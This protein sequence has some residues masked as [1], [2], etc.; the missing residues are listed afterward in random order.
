MR[1]T[2]TTFE[3][4][5][6]G[7]ARVRAPRDDL[8]LERAE[9]PDRFACETGPFEAYERTVD[10]EDLGDGRHRVTETT[11]WVLGI[12]IWGVLFRPLVSRQIARHEA[13]PAPDPVS[14]GDEPGTEPAALTSPWWSPPARLDLRSSQVLSRLCGLSLLAGYLGTVLTQTITY[15]ADEFGSSK[16][17]Q[18]GA[19]AAVRLGV[20][21]SVAIMAVADRRGRQ[22]LL[23]V[24]AVGGSVAAGLTA[25]APGLVVLGATQTV[26]R[27]FS[28]ALALLISVVA[29]EEMPSGGRA[30]AASVMAMTGA[31]GAG[32][33]VMLLPVADVAEPAWRLLYVVPLLALPLFLKIGRRLPESRRFARSHGRST[34][35]GHRMRLLLLAASSFFA[36]VFFAPNTQFQ[37]DFLRDEHGFTA[38]QI[39]IFTILTNT[40]G[41]IGIVVGGRLADTRGRRLV[42]AVG[43]IGGAVLL[44]LRFLVGG[45][46]LW[47]LS[48]A[49]TIVAAVT[50]PALAVYGPELFPTALRGKANGYISVAGVAGSAVGLV[51]AGRLADRYGELGPGLAMLAVGP[52][53]VAALVMAFYPET[54]HLELEDLNPEDAPS[55]ITPL[56]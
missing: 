42:G 13:P 21:L 50:V 39:T 7:L 30:Y 27:A 12:P 35:A 49:G 9:G 24:C 46:F 55:F 41:G 16:S 25:L 37:N 6:E 33:A 31:L 43:T 53:V 22:K 56:S 19:L 18:G 20:L 26:S 8:V 48:I 5:D 4:D 15:A 3:V 10:V 1:T 51:A 11:S 17:A 23:V 52:L 44:G 14:A 40:P 38:I 47:I 29:A 54:A 2:T 32:V 28:T 45:P 34:L 36:L